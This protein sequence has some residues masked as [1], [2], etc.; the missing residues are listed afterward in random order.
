MSPRGLELQMTQIHEFRV[1]PVNRFVLT[2]YRRNDG[3]NEG[4]S[5][6]AT[7][8]AELPNAKLADQLGEA[9]QRANPGSTLVNSEGEHTPARSREF[10]IVEA[11]TFVPDALVYYAYN[12][13]EAVIMQT[14]AQMMHKREFKVFERTVLS[15]P[16]AARDLQA[17][18][19]AASRINRA[20]VGAADALGAICSANFAMGE[21]V[22]RCATDIRLNGPGQDGILNRCEAEEAEIAGVH[23]YPGKVCYDVVFPSGRRMETVDSCEISKLQPGTASEVVTAM[24]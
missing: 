21:R 18:V 4:S 24:P 7:T 5:G 6:T 23:F 19:D 12:E 14:N 8:I 20:W 15:D 16:N 11:H 1:R 10:V 3:P 22:M 2:E 17:P 9:L 13:Q